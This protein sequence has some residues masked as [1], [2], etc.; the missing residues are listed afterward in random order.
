[1]KKIKIG[2]VGVGNMGQAAHLQNYATLEEC[3]VVALAEIRPELGRAVAQRWGVRNVYADHRQMLA[4]EDVDAL[5]CIQPFQFHG[6]LLPDVFAKGVPVMTEKPLAWSVA[7][8]EKLAAQGQKHFVGYHK[9]SDPAGLFAR[10]Q[11]DSFRASGTVGGM[12]LVRVTMP[13][14]DWISNGFWQLCP[15]SEKALAWDRPGDAPAE[16]PDEAKTKQYFRFVNYYIHQVNL[17]RYLLGGENYTVKFADRSGCI[18]A[19]NSDSGVAVVLEMASYQ[20]T[21]DWQESALVTFERGWVKLD[22]PSPLVINQ[23]GRVTIHE[24]PKS[25]EPRTWSPTLPTVHAMRNQA[26]EFLKAVR[27]EQTLLCR[28]AEALEDLRV[29]REYLDLFLKSA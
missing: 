11:I 24:D 2:F 4:N 28:P 26:M 22:L 16:Y 18:L 12:R 27:G 21:R 10:R 7:V 29:A 1:M 15:T 3:E 6:A 9:R 17:I 8:G 13:P 5:V 25:G 23:S 14:G 20:T 19:G